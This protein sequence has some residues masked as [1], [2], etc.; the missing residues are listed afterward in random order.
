MGL[1]CKSV[2]GFFWVLLGVCFWGC[3]FGLVGVLGCV[4][5]FLWGV[6]GCFLV[7]CLSLVLTG[8]C[9]VW[10]ACILGGFFF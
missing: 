3:V 1:A 9:E 7:W 8:S 4:G 10:F 6:Y 5:W 2:L